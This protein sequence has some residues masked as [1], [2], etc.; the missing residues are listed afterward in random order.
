MNNIRTN[1][2]IYPVLAGHVEHLGGWLGNDCQYYYNNC[3]SACGKGRHVYALILK[4]LSTWCALDRTRLLSAG[5]MAEKRGRWSA[6]GLKWP[7]NGRWPT[8]IF[9][10][11]YF[12]PCA[13][14][15]GKNVHSIHVG[16]MCLDY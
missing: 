15:R 14:A 12:I 6:I 4:L 8:V 3:L 10:P 13:C 11:G 9:T 5:Q 1:V 7:E 2:R 16:A